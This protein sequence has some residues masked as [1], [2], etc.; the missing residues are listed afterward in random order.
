M[1]NR[2]SSHQWMSRLCLVLFL[3]AFQRLLLPAQTLIS[4][5]INDYTSVSAINAGT[6]TLTVADPGLFAFDDRV[7]LIQMQGAVI[8]SADNS[9]FGTITNLNGAGAYEFASVCEIDAGANEV[10]LQKPLVHSYNPASVSQ[11][12][13][14]L[15]KVPQYADVNIVGTLLAQQWNGSTGGIIAFESTGT[16]R[17]EADIDVSGAGFRG[18]GFEVL[19]SSCGFLTN[20]NDWYYSQSDGRGGKKGEGISAYISNR[21]YGRGPQANGGGGGN[22]HNTGGAGGGNYSSG[23]QGGERVSGVICP[24]NH[25]GEAGLNLSGFGYSAVNPFAFMGGGGGC[26]HGNNVGNGEDGGD[27]GGIVMIRAQTFNGNG[28]S[29]LANGLTAVDALSDGGSGGG[30][31][32]AIM[33]SADFYTADPFTLQA[34]GGDGGDTDINCE[35]PGGGGAGGVLWVSNALGAGVTRSVAAGVNG[36]ATGSGCGN[37][38]QGAIGGTAGVELNTLTLTESSSATTCVLPIVI[39]S[40]DAKKMQ[41]QVELT[42]SSAYE[43]PGTRFIIERSM[44]GRSFH[45]VDEI[46]GQGEG[47]HTYAYLD[48]FPLTRSSWYRLH[49]QE[50]G[51]AEGYSSKVE[52]SLSENLSNSFAILSQPSKV[53]S[54]VILSVNSLFRTEVK[55]HLTSM[56]G[57]ILT[58]KSTP[59]EAGRSRLTLDTKG[60]PAGFYV[61]SVT[62]R[63]QKFT[64]KCRLY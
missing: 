36:I 59:I 52:V 62:I 49:W 25:E 28:Y 58:E 33:L 38:A 19:N 2:I 32:G 16:V 12:S 29:I 45:H 21:E 6:S 63:G 44:D 8:N 11:A 61:I 35:G 64:Q 5:I 41:E 10:I 47:A 40:F 54:P 30:A 51:G 17:L 43:L 48:P 55:I 27:G 57:K 26:G 42:W 14:Q 4:G 18:G 22:D 39:T 3:C 13:I 46:M 34:I 9:S 23:G 53:G 37:S 7:L 1:R 60:V 50:A 20:N 31:G 15:I 24:G 56:E